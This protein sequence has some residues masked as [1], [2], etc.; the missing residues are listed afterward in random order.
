M[1]S[2]AID[3]TNIFRLCSY[4]TIVID[5]ITTYNKI[6]KEM[7]FLYPSTDEALHRIPFCICGNSQIFLRLLLRISPENFKERLTEKFTQI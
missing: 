2:H 5:I 1:F 3:D 4:Y 7:I 6:N